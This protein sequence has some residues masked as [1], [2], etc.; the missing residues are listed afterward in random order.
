MLESQSVLLHGALSFLNGK[1]K[2]EEGFRT[3]KNPATSFETAGFDFG[4]IRTL[5]N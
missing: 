2:Q 1:Y 3:Q 5:A 4:S